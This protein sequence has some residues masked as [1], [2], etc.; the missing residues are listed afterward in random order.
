LFDSEVVT[1]PP[2]GRLELTVDL[3]DCAAQVDLFYGPLLPNLMGQRYAERLIEGIQ[4]GTPNYCT[5]PTP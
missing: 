4:L 2:G 3:P 1:I 5:R